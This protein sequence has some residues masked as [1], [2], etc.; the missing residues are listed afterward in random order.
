MIEHVQIRLYER[1]MDVMYGGYAHGDAYILFSVTVILA[2]RLQ[3]ELT[4]EARC[5]LA[6]CDKTQIT[7]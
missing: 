4:R 3:L 2:R 7:T 1:L 5:R 6:Q